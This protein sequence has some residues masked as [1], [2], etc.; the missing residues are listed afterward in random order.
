MP[1]EFTGTP[2]IYLVYQRAAGRQ[3]SSLW[4]VTILASGRRRGNRDGE[5]SYNLVWRVSG[6]VWRTESAPTV[7]VRPDQPCPRAQRCSCRK[8]RDG[9]IRGSHEHPEQTER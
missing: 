8:P 6:G 7:R 9:F 3:T 5:I 2:K 4:Y 1:P